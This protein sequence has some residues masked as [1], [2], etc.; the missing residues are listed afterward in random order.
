MEDGDTQIQCLPGQAAKPRPPR[1][2]R[3]QQAVRGYYPKGSITRK[4]SWTKLVTA[5]VEVR[6]LWIS[7]FPCFPN[8]GSRSK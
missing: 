4:Y 5:S 2:R 1:L 7:E 8:L 6:S 3:V